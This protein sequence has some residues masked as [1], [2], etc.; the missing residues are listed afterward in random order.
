MSLRSKLALGAATALAASVTLAGGTAVA[1]GT[2]HTTTK[3][4][5]STTYVVLKGGATTLALD[6]GTAAALTS[7]GISVAPA[8]EARVRP[9]GVAFPI[10]GGLINAKTLSGRITHSGGLTFSAGGKDLTIRD[11]TVNT[12]KKTLTAYVDQVGA[13][14]TVLDLRLGRAKVN[15][16]ARH[17]TI[18]NVKAVLSDGAASALNAYYATNLFSGGLKIG[19]ATVSA[20]SK[21]VRG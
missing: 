16:T 12:A 10:Q 2:H 4:A 13:R 15:V 7:A 19:T 3:Q 17:T 6:P 1:S 14:L 5:A 9:S 21:T 18:S 20:S 8:S 11:F